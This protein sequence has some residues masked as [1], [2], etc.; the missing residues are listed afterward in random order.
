MEHLLLTLSIPQWCDC[1]GS[2]TVNLRRA[3]GIFQSHNGAIAAIVDAELG[4][5]RQ[6]HFQSH[7]GAIAAWERRR[8]QV[9]LK[10]FNPTM[11]RL[12][13]ISPSFKFPPRRN[14]FN[15]TMVRLLPG[16]NVGMSGRFTFNPTM[17]RLLLSL[18]LLMWTSQKFFQSHNGAIAASQPL[19][20]W[21]QAAAFNPTMVRLLHASCRC[22]PH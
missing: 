4:L 21:Q 16:R 8:R 9:Q 5:L 2:G 3:T 7:N 13:P 19:T 17:V 11:V 12:L 1:C 10:P 14:P 22:L 18:P 15:P 6:I 20:D